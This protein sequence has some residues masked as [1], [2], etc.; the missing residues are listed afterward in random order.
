LA[1][2]EDIAPLV[3]AYGA[4]FDGFLDG[5]VEGVVAGGV[6]T[7]DLPGANGGDQDECEHGDLEH[8][9]GFA[10]EICTS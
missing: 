3:G 5:V 7:M 1:A 10:N 6:A 9:L 4:A 8:L 2:L